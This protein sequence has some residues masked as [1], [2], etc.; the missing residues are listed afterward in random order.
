MWCNY[1]YYIFN[2]A[3]CD[4]VETFVL[5]SQWGARKMMFD[6]DFH[7]I[8]L[9]LWK[10]TSRTVT[11]TYLKLSQTKQRQLLMQSAMGFFINR[12]NSASESLKCSEW[13]GSREQG[14]TLP[15]F[16]LT[17]EMEKSNMSMCLEVK[18]KKMCERLSFFVRALL[19]CYI[20]YAQALL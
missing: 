14:G 15:S 13:R 12:L 8:L 9:A 3:S 6:T 7:V 5:G 4:I 16:I 11:H 19:V 2:N 1:N 20:T 18:K 10:Q 17:P